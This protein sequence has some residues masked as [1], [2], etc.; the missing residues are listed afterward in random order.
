MSSFFYIPSD[1]LK[2]QEILSR[3]QRKPKMGVYQCGC[4]HLS[5]YD[6]VDQ[7]YHIPFTCCHIE[8][9]VEQRFFIPLEG[10]IEKFVLR[11]AL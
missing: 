5:G 6:F 2:C 3:A 10:I 9:P 4:G 1:C 8:H 11:G 7:E